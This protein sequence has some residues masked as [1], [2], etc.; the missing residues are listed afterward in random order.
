MSLYGQGTG[1][2]QRFMDDLLA[3]CLSNPVIQKVV[4]FGSRARGDYR[5]TSDIDLAIYTNNATHSQQ[6]L[7][8]YQI[9]EMPILL[10]I[11][12]LFMDRVSEEKLIANIEKDGMVVYETRKDSTKS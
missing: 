9:Q 11:D 8:E 1:I 10:K 2:S 3:Y 12:I 6:N 7:I 5:K 4:L